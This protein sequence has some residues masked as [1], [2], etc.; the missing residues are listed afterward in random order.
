MRRY[1]G[2]WRRPLDPTLLRTDALFAHNGLAHGFTTRAGG[3]SPAPRASLHL[4]LRPDDE[5][6]HVME[7][8]E[9]VA[10]AVG[11]TAERLVLLDQVHGAEVVVATGPT[12]P[13]STL[14]PADGVVTAVPDLLLAVR[15]ADCVPVLLA[16]PGGVG[17]AHAGWRGLVAGVLPR[18]VQALCAVAGCAPSE[19][20]AAI[21]PHAGVDAY[22]TGP[23]VVDALVG[24]GLARERVGVLG[25]R[26]REHAHLAHAAEDQLTRAGV[27]VVERVE[28][29]TVSDPEFFSHRRDGASTGRQA[30]VIR[31]PEAL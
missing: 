14:A 19:V 18:T 8:W 25:P 23:A 30:G 16:A 2:P 5:P 27:R 15:T 4:A 6:A 1:G 22:E 11:S 17:A 3:V 13:L 24:A 9:R 10:R 26:G 28:R 7:N 12:G 20:V 29:C 21:G 31:L